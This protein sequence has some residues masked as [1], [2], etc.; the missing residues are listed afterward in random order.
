MQNQGTVPG[1]CGEQYN[2]ILPY[3]IL[4]VEETETTTNLSVDTLKIDAGKI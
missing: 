4:S 2:I 1:F 3:T